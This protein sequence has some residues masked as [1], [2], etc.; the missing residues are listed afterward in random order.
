M[1]QQAAAKLGGYAM[2][3]ADVSTIAISDDEHRRELRKAVIAST[4]GTTI[5][6]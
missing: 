2:A 6:W 4:V 1:L 3:A 5:E